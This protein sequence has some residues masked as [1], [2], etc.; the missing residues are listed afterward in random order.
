MKEEVRVKSEDLFSHVPCEGDGVVSPR[1]CHACA[2]GV[3]C[4][5]IREEEFEH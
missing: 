2:E 3:T 1:Q 5:G 4:V